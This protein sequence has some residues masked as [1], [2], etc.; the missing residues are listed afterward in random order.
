MIELFSVY[1]MIRVHTIEVG[2][3]FRS[4]ETCLANAKAL[5]EDNSGIRFSCK[6]IR[7]KKIP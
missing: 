1:F 2:R 4:E 7:V 6:K 5:S 3:Y